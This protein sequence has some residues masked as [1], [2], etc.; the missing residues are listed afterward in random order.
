[1]TEDIWDESIHDW[2]PE[3]KSVKQLFGEIRSLDK[4]KE[5]FV[6]YTPVTYYFVADQ[7]RTACSTDIMSNILASV[8]QEHPLVITETEH[9]I[10]NVS[11]TLL[12]KEE[13]KMFRRAIY[14]VPTEVWQ[15]AES[16]LKTLN[17]FDRDTRRFCIFRP[18]KETVPCPFGQH[19]HQSLD[20]W[21]FNCY[22]NKET[23][24]FYPAETIQVPEH[25]ESTK[26]VM[27]VLHY[28]APIKEIVDIGETI[29]RA[30]EQ[31]Q[32]TSALGSTP[33]DY[34][35]QS[36][37]IESFFE[38]QQ[39]FEERMAAI[40]KKN[41]VHETL[42]AKPLDESQLS[43]QARNECYELIKKYRE[44]YGDPPESAY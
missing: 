42:A 20:I 24:Y 12:L 44:I 28:R 19:E 1:M 43:V 17:I 32:R 41:K 27:S 23:Y 6:F 34:L 4:L 26:P 35:Q 13:H 29:F 18:H 22:G 5:R 36:V 10:F 8:L 15:K 11:E 14:A 31:Q 16:S 40:Q 38:K 30:L 21:Y 9:P 3:Q 2:K 7:A 37:T 39:T 25:L 33:P